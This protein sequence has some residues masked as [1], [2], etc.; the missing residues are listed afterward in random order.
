MHWNSSTFASM[1]FSWKYHFC[2]ELG[3]FSYFESIYG[4]QIGW[5]A[6]C[7][8]YLCNPPSR[9][10]LF[11]PIMPGEEGIGA[12]WREGPEPHPNNL[13][14]VCSKAA[15]CHPLKQPDFYLSL[16]NSFEGPDVSILLAKA[17]LCVRVLYVC[18]WQ[19]QTWLS[20]KV[21]NRYSPAIHLTLWMYFESVSADH[22]AQVAQCLTRPSSELPIT[23]GWTPSHNHKGLGI[24]CYKWMLL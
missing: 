10:A 22:W 5:H 19:D 6:C 1:F 7:C 4:G 14:D 12:Q 23:Q 18:L 9:A 2:S 15:A 3:G 17:C 11:T 8:C 24:C 13:K 16:G 21:Q 20:G